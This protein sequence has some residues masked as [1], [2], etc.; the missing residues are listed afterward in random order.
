MST[1]LNDLASRVEA[2]TGA[3]RE[4][5]LAIHH[6]VQLKRYRWAE[7]GGMYEQDHVAVEEP[8]PYV[9]SMIE[10]QGHV[11]RSLWEPDILAIPRY[12]GSIDA[13]MSLVPEGVNIGLHIDQNGCDCAWS[14]RA[15][16]WQPRVAPGNSP[17]L[18]LTAAALRARAHQGPT[19]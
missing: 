14:S 4:L 18:A 7:F 9:A 3:D 8:P 11:P 16:G 12:S 19:T 15:V 17:A 6:A 2:A 1:D 10:E 13:A 5:D